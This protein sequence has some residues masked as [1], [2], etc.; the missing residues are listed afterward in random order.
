MGIR[1]KIVGKKAVKVKFCDVCNRDLK[2]SDILRVCKSC[3]RHY[4]EECSGETKFPICKKCSGPCE[5]CGA[6]STEQL[7]A[8]GID[9]CPECGLKVKK[10]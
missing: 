6:Y 8:A 1:N 7:I 5:G 4:C 2:K 3:E 9:N 10:K